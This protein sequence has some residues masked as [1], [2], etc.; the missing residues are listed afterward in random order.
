MLVLT[1]K[2]CSGKDTIKKELVKLGMNPI[3]AYTTRPM[4]DGEVNGE[5]YNFIS[6]DKFMKKIDE[7]FFAEYTHYNVAN[8]ETWFYGSSLHDYVD[9][10]VIILNPYGAI[11]AFRKCEKKPKIFYLKVSDDTIKMRLWRRG[12]NPLEAERRVMADSIDFED[13]IYGDWA[14]WEI[15]NNDD[16]NPEEI[17]KTIYKLYKEWS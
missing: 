3:I 8:G 6:K 5:T 2:T 12:D 15:E 4:R 11:E 17:A 7:D 1:G 9:N 10:G 16:E 13:F 14:D